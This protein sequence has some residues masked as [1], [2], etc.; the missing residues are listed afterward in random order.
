MLSVECT[1]DHPC[2]SGA[3]TLQHAITLGDVLVFTGIGFGLVIAIGIIVAI[4][5][6]YANGFRD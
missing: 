3:S 5:V 1:T 2:T 4:L 6:F